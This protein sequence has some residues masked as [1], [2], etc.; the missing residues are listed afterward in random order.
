MLRGLLDDLTRISQ[1]PEQFLAFY[2]GYGKV[3][4]LRLIQG[5]VSISGS[6]V[7]CAGFENGTAGWLQ[8]LRSSLL[9]G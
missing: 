1:G 3:C 2:S 8:G 5:F 6:T 4:L 9:S 7:S